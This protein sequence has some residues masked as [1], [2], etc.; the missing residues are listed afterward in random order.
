MLPHPT[1][2]TASAAALAPAAH[3]QSSSQGATLTQVATF[4]QQV[5][6][7]A[8][9]PDGRIF[10]NFPRWEEDVA[11]SV[12]ELKDGRV[13]PYPNAEWNA[14]RNAKP[15]SRGDHLICVQ[16][17]FSDGRGNLWI[18][19]PAAPGNEFNLDGGPNN[20]DWAIP[21][22]YTIDPRTMKIAKAEVG[23]DSQATS[24]P[25]IDTMLGKNP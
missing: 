11:I 5:T 14:W 17:V 20:G 8:V 23:F 13:T 4:E 3:E 10:V 22:I 6:G 16:S 15:L 21:T 1:P 7:V 12:G 2:I 25:G 19:D 18:L 24:F 9:T